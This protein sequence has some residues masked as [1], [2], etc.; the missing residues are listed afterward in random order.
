M[1]AVLHDNPL[2]QVI[3]TWFTDI[4]LRI[5]QLI[6]HRRIYILHCPLRQ[7]DTFFLFLVEEIYGQLFFSFKPKTFSVYMYDAFVVALV[8]FHETNVPHSSS[9]LVFIQIAYKT[10]QHFTPIRSPFIT[11]YSEW[12]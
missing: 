1:R 2:Y 7:S 12:K 9:T 10:F 8:H 11:I 5:P 4:F 3:I 6:V